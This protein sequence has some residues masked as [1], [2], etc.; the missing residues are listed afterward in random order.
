MDPKRSPTLGLWFNN[1]KLDALIEDEVAFLDKNRETCKGI[2][3]KQDIVFWTK[4]LITFR[5][6]MME[7]Y[8]NFYLFESTDLVFVEL[9][10]KL[11][12][13]KGPAKMLTY[14]SD[15]ASM[16]SKFQTPSLLDN[17][18]RLG[19][20]DTSNK[21]YGHL[22]PQK[23]EKLFREY[24]KGVLSPAEQLEVKDQVVQVCSISSRTAAFIVQLLQSLLKGESPLQGWKMPDVWRQKTWQPKELEEY[25][26]DKW[27]DDLA[28]IV[29]QVPQKDIAWWNKKKQKVL[30]ESETI[31]TEN[32]FSL[33]MMETMPWKPETCSKLPPCLADEEWESV[34]DVLRRH[35]PNNKLPFEAFPSDRLVKL[36]FECFQLAVP[37]VL[38]LKY[39]KRKLDGQH[40]L[41][42]SAWFASWCLLLSG[43]E[44]MRHVRATSP[45]GKCANFE[46]QTHLLAIKQTLMHWNVPKALK[47]EDWISNVSDFLE[48]NSVQR[49]FYSNYT[50]RQQ[51]FAVALSAILKF[52]LHTAPLRFWPVPAKHA[53][54]V[55]EVLSFVKM[56]KELILLGIY[57]HESNLYEEI[58]AYFVTISPTV[59]NCIKLISSNDWTECLRNL[60][61]KCSLSSKGKFVSVP[62]Y[63]LDKDVSKFYSQHPW[64][65][66]YYIDLHLKKPDCN[67]MLVSKTA[68]SILNQWRNPEKSVGTWSYTPNFHGLLNNTA[69]SLVR[70][71]GWSKKGKFVKEIVGVITHMQF[72][73]WEDKP[74]IMHTELD[75]DKFDKPISAMQ[76]GDYGKMELIGKIGCHCLVLLSAGHR[77]KMLLG[78]KKEN[79]IATLVRQSYQLF[80][81]EHLYRI[82]LLVGNLCDFIPEA[83]INEGKESNYSA[84]ISSI[85]QLKVQQT[86]VPDPFATRKEWI[87]EDVPCMFEFGPKDCKYWLKKTLSAQLK[88]IFKEASEGKS[89]PAHTPIM[90]YLLPSYF[91]LLD[92]DGLSRQ[93][94]SL[95]F[96]VLVK[97]LQ[98][99]QKY[100]LPEVPSSELSISLLKSNTLAIQ[101]KLLQ[102][103]FGTIDFLK[104]K[105]S[106]NL[107]EV[108]SSMN[109]CFDTPQQTMAFCK[110]MRASASKIFQEQ[111]GTNLQIFFDTCI[112]ESE[113]KK[114]T[115]LNTCNSPKLDRLVTLNRATLTM[116]IVI[117]H[118]QSFDH[119][120]EFRNVMSQLS[121]AEKEAHCWRSLLYLRTS[122]FAPSDNQDGQFIEDAFGVL[123]NVWKFLRRARELVKNLKTTK[124]KLEDS[125]YGK[126]VRAFMAGKLDEAEIHLQFRSAPLPKK[127]ESPKHFASIEEEEEAKKEF[128]N[129]MK[130]V[131]ED[132][133]AVDHE[134][135]RMMSENIFQEGLKKTCTCSCCPANIENEDEDNSSES[136]S[137]C[138]DEKTSKCKKF[139][140]P[141]K[142]VLKVL[143][144]QTKD[145][146][147]RTCHVCKKKESN[148][149]NYITCS[150]CAKTDFP[151][152]NYYCSKAC[153][154]KAWETYHEE[155]HLLHELEKSYY[156]TEGRDRSK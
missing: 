53:E 70:D 96:S 129:A 103:T 137:A 43:S 76:D 87:M 99:Y 3:A 67:E 35:V 81:L 156:G 142:E 151:D 23:L 69:Y 8:G 59:T 89:V 36:K 52:E 24:S 50:I 117:N 32:M 135:A 126:A 78:S 47:P 16:E 29:L 141:T 118:E 106:Q 73:P 49:Q 97:L 37:P 95:L 102:I 119:G 7:V 152:V 55:T 140:K 2:I 123:F 124:S 121:I 57:V 80:E 58:N 42:I 128:E 44:L 33:K 15:V 4:A 127:E 25:L 41:C 111:L 105:F 98:K 110:N 145:K 1:Y 94:K 77:C 9:L 155:D 154:K 72:V 10:R 132:L 114:Y 146:E 5:D 79:L 14:L 82:A 18:E 139:L 130:N 30:P 88:V 61:A 65:F 144:Q 45:T 112:N 12:G 63:D 147:R 6:A 100:P 26:K 56:I 122:K 46:N 108:F 85:K 38:A 71:S 19:H 83:P 28:K 92:S 133:F 54:A 21:L 27:R 149:L 148:K 13:K 131:F 48:C 90:Q 75:T 60:A 116:M 40:S 93:G 11:C 150:E 31:S 109:W 62:S 134:T 74:R 91:G 22:L 143:E 84:L 113:I 20:K 68:V 120:S 64:N 125:N 104:G 107:M 66:L 101:N 17:I 136:T 115:K 34:F 39:H 138:A 51:W 153:E 86:G